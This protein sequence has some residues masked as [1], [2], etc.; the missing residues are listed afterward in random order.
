MSRGRL[1]RGRPATAGVSAPADRRFRR[2]ESRP[3]RRVRIGRTLWRLTRVVAPI[4]LIVV[5]IGW[6]GQVLLASRLLAVD[7]I[8]VHGTTRLSGGEV[9]VLLDGIRG[10]NLLR[11]DLDE[12]RRRVLDSPWVADVTL[13]RQLPSTIEVRVVERIPMALARVGDHL[14]LVDRTGVIVDEFGPQYQEFQLPIIDGLIA[15]PS[16]AGKAATEAGR[17][18]LA[19]RFIEAMAAAPELRRRLS[20]VDVSDARNARV[21]LDGELAWLHIGD[22]A[23]AER[24]QSYVEIAPALQGRFTEIDYVDMRFY[25]RIFVADNTGRRE[26]RR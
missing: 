1:L 19:A 10:R 22:E 18:R 11:I 3:S 9:E 13:W 4:A 25:P 17:V 12:Y 26:A 6:F 14:F 21:L 8:V 16:A 20:Q 24:L 2:A 23:F 7:R 15:S 5:T